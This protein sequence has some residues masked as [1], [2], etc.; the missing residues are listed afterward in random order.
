MKRSRPLTRLPGRALF[1][2]RAEAEILSGAQYGS[3]ARL[4]GFK[5]LDHFKQI[6]DRQGNLGGTPSEE[7]VATLRECGR[8][9]TSL[10]GSWDE[11]VV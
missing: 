9:R 5:S 8:A 6:N 7:E 1:F 10:A 11:F 3:T 2:Q 4:P